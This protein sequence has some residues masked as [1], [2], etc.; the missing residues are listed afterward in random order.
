M[1][2]WLAAAAAPILIHLWMRQTHRE[3]AW[4]AVR[5]LRAALEKQARKLR[6]QHW[7]LLATR[8]LLLA[9]LALAAAKPL[10]DSGLLGAGTPTHRVIVVDASLSMKSLD[11]EGRTAL[12]KAKQIALSIV[13]SARAGDT[14]S[15]VVM[16]T[17]AG[18]PLGRPTSDAVAARRAVDAIAPSQGVADLGAALAAVSSLVQSAGESSS[19]QRQEVVFLS[20][21]GEN[22]WSKLASQDDAQAARETY[23]VVAQVAEVSLIDVGGSSLPSAGVASFTLTEG[24]PTLAAP[25]EFTGEIR[26]D[27]GQPGERE[28]ELRVDDVVVAQRRINLD[29]GAPTPVGFPHRFDSPGLK[30]IELR[31]ADNGEDR[32]RDDDRRYLALSLTPRVRVLC[33]AGAPGAADYLADALDPT[34]EGA[35]EPVVISDADLPTAEL[36]EYACVFLSNVRELT[37]SETQRLVRYAAAGGG[38]GLFLGD[39][40]DA[41]RFNESLA[42]P[43]RGAS[44][45]FSAATPS[46]E[47]LVKAAE[48]GG[49]SPEEAVQIDTLSPGWLS[50]SVSAPSYR[51]DPLD[52]EHPVV[53]PFRGWE[54]AGLLTTP[55][56]RHF[57]L[58]LPTGGAAEVALTLDNGDP[59]L[60]TAPIGRGRVALLTTAATLDS[61]DPTTGEAWTALPA[62]PSFLPIVRELT[63]YLARG[64]ALGGGLL[65]G[66]TIVG[67]IPTGAAEVQIV[68]PGDGKPSRVAAD[69]AGRWSFNATGRSGVYAYGPD[70]GAPDAAVAVNVDPLECDPSTVVPD[71]LPESLKVRRSVGDASS[72]AAATAPTPLHRWLLYTALALALV[73]PAMACWFGRGSG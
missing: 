18:A 37:P 66:E 64:E 50:P 58:T 73:E 8:T 41:A 56:L 42:P 3:T 16:G 15:L 57:P 5:F 40:V 46:G 69:A 21:L 4:A 6:L 63:R 29:A 19:T 60:V 65:V 45:G 43:R 10:L 72:D 33:V 35:Y 11:A 59:L 62:W 23:E 47:P 26:L 14:H 31:L 61:L 48:N 55:V 25:V 36:S 67:T 1:L 54:R 12:E 70:G 27:S 28:V 32:L 71:R 22:T 34:G 68:P 7:I 20:D 9:L 38:V 24:L 52:Y 49:A 30:H 51:V 53:R 44:G 39:R 13:D 2:G 17:D